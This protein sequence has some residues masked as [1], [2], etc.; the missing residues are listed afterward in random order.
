MLLVSMREKIWEKL[1]Q[2]KKLR[3]ILEAE[4]LIKSPGSYV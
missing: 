1:L 2:K 3:E 4:K